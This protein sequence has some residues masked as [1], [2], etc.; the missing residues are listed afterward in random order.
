MH[1]TQSDRHNESQYLYMIKHY[2]CVAY[3]VRQYTNSSEEITYSISC[4][5]NLPNLF[6]AQIAAV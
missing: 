4:I 1:S 2:N 6:E 5:L 3:V